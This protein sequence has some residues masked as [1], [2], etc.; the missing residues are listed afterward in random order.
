[1]PDAPRR[2]ARG[3]DAV[4][5]RRGARDESHRR[6]AAADHGARALLPARLAG[7]RAA[8]PAPRWPAGAGRGHDS[9]G[10]RRPPLVRLLLV[11]WSR[12][13]SALR[14]YIATAHAIADTSP[15]VE[16]FWLRVHTVIGE[17][18]ARLNDYEH[19]DV[20]RRDRIVRSAGRRLVATY[21][22]VELAEALAD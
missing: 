19:F 10:A 20:A 14:R 18:A 6:A 8:A 17:L 4:Q 22:A 21:D 16:D 15:E 2:R 13:L 1:Q 12:A 3:D 7:G 5:H 11:G 9:D